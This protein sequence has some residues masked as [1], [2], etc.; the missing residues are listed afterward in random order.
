[1]SSS[2]IDD[3]ANRRHLPEVLRPRRERELPLE[4]L[5]RMACGSATRADVDEYGD[6]WTKTLVDLLQRGGIGS[7]VARMAGSPL[8]SPTSSRARRKRGT[9]RSPTSRLRGKRDA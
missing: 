7:S 9:A 1:M 8:C 4:R 2:I 6:H 3:L 5:W